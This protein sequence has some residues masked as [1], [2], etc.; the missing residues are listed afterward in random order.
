MLQ[1]GP[2]QFRFP[3]S[4]LHLLDCLILPAVLRSLRTTQIVTNE[5]W[6]SS[7]GAKGCR[8]GRRADNL[9]A[10][11]E[12]V[13]YKKWEHGCLI[14]YRSP[15]PVIRI[16]SPSDVLQ[17]AKRYAAPCGYATL[18]SVA[19]GGGDRSDMIYDHRSTVN[20]ATTENKATGRGGL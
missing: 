2:S 5:D 4:P 17:H 7:S 3:M 15:R 9:T 14:P 16:A 13:A 11:C 12:P 20:T 19:R 18:V 1:T 10:I 6:E 8:P